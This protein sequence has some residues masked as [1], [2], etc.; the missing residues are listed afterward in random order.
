MAMEVVDP[1]SQ[2]IRRPRF[3]P[4]RGYMTIEQPQTRQ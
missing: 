1:G 4:D 2:Q 3:T